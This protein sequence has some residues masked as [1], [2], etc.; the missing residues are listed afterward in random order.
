MKSLTSIGEQLL[1]SYIQW[2]C[3]FVKM[4]FECWILCHNCE[5]F[6]HKVNQS[7]NGILRN[8]KEL[9]LTPPTNVSILVW[10]VKT[11]KV[12]KSLRS[13]INMSSFLNLKGNGKCTLLQT[14][15]NRRNQQP[16]NSYKFKGLTKS[17]VL[18]SYLSSTTPT[19]TPLPS[20]LSTDGTLSS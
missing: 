12:L 1:F 8:V 4:W 15:C 18:K 17:T 19:L 16:S 6:W 5:Y 2:G 9:L 7:I 11:A 14:S 20:Q 3:K 13:N 10:I